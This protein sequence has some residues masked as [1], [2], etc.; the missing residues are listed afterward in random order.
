MMP[1]NLGSNR[2]LGRFSGFHRLRKTAAT[3]PGGEESVLG[4]D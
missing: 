1:S 3:P 4:A 2:G